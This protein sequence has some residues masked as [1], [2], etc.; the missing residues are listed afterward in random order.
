MSSDDVLSNILQ[1]SFLNIDDYM[2]VK[3]AL[4]LLE[5]LMRLGVF[6]DWVSE[7]VPYI[8]PAPKRNFYRLL[9]LRLLRVTETEKRFKKAIWREEDEFNR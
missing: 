2:R 7:G 6:D 1:G 3:Y 9:A 5:H 4:R 8:P